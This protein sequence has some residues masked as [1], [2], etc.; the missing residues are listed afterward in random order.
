MMMDPSLATESVMSFAH[1]ASNVAQLI[2]EPQDQVVSMAN[3]APTIA[4]LTYMRAF[5]ASPMAMDAGTGMGLY[6]LGQRTKG[7]INKS[8]PTY[9]IL[10]RWMII[11]L[12]DGWVA[13]E[14]YKIVQHLVVDQTNLGH[15]PAALLM[16]FL[17]SATYTPA[18]CVAF[19]GGLSLLEGKGIAGAKARID[20]DFLPMC[21]ATVSTWGLLN[22]F[23]FGFV[24]LEQR[25][26]VAMTAHYLYLIVLALWNEGGYKEAAEEAAAI[27]EEQE[28]TPLIGTLEVLEE[29]RE[30]LEEAKEKL[31]EE[32]VLAMKDEELGFIGEKLEQ[33]E[34]AVE[35]AGIEAMEVGVDVL[36]AGVEAAE[37]VVE[38]ATETFIEILDTP[39]V[40]MEAMMDVAPGP[41][42][43]DLEHEIGEQVEQK[44]EKK[45]KSKV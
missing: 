35:N 11:G 26:S 37:A 29:L 2:Q 43:L 15:W 19:L 14:W 21:K 31:E 33:V 3:M 4:Q 5:E 41:L 28:L 9:D 25:V 40:G 23:L 38:A 10:F 22:L 44:A 17:T 1:M 32:H 16:T 13:H 45:E 34:F 6:Y 20:S 36:E 30:D 39:K 24:K 7:F 18:Y 27:A 8:Q 12:A 42:A